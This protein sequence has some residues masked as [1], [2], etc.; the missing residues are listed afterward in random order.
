[1]SFLELQAVEVER[2]HNR[3]HVTLE[4]M[5]Y[6]CTRHLQQGTHILLIFSI[7]L[8]SIKADQPGRLWDEV[9][10]D[11][12]DMNLREELLR[13]MDAYGFDTPSAIQQ[14][15]IVPCIKGELRL[16]STCTRATC[17]QCIPHTREMGGTRQ[18]YPP[19]CVHVWT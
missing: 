13:G 7:V 15:A 10:D 12:A 8:D 5:S 19:P 2:P 4:S 14:H 1:M 9:V 6:A 16:R 11:F 17:F 18:L 3:N